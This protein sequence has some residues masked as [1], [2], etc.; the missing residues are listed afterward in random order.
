MLKA[1][2]KK[3][4]QDSPGK[5]FS[6]WQVELT[7]RCPLECRMCSRAA[8]KDFYRKDMPLENFKKL[9]PY[10]SQVESLVLEGWGESLLHK[11][12]IECIRLAKKEGPRVGFVTSGKGFNE[13]LIRE[14]LD[15]GVDFMG[16]SISGATARTHNFIRVNS[17]LDDVLRWIRVVQETKAGK[18]LPNPQLHIV[19]LLL[20]D[21]IAEVPALIALARDLEITEVVLIHLSHVSNAWQEEQKAFSAEGREEWEDVLREA[22]EKAREWGIDLQRPSVSFGEA[23]VCAENPLRNLYLSVEGEV[24]PCVY[25]NPPVPSPF[26][27]IYQGAEVQVDKVSFGNIFREPF[28]GIWDSPGYSQFRGCFARRKAHFDEMLSSLWEPDRLK[29]MEGIAPPP[30]PGPCQTCYKMLRL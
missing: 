11:D 3:I 18:R 28:E 26:K 21:N 23:P 5:M 8:Y 2:W 29:K 7:T 27:R 14:V 12:L 6:A 9:L 22:E 15:A 19:Y 13:P 10:F 1:L 24:S 17:D 30:P 4:F 20:K 25:L 16:F